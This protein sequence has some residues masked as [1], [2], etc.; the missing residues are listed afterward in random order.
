MENRAFRKFEWSVW[1]LLD[2]RILHQIPKGFWEPWAA[3]KPPAVSNEPSSENF[4]LR[5]CILWWPPS[6]IIATYLYCLLHC[7][8]HCQN[9][10]FKNK[11]NSFLIS[12]I[13]LNNAYMIRQKLFHLKKHPVYT[14]FVHL[15]WRYGLWE[16]KLWYTMNR[17][18]F[19]VCGFLVIGATLYFSINIGF[20][21]FLK[22]YIL[23][24]II[25]NPNLSWQ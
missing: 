19:V 1:K 9:Q 8:L 4:W 23:M 12:F 7:L 2:C 14:G 24:N 10:H 21:K 15:C 5:A 25:I 3:P 18:I 20:A 16:S 6:P 22:K 13:L 11:L 17:A